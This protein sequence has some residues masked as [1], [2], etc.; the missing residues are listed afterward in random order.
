MSFILLY[1]P[2]CSLYSGFEFGTSGSSQMSLFR[3]GHGL[4][5]S[6]ASLPRVVGLNICIIWPMTNDRQPIA[7]DISPL[8]S[9][10]IL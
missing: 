6:R 5:L 4:I 10:H 8:F 1:H 7:L 9:S 2:Y 3:H